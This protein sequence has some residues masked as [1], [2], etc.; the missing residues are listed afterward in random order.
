VG[1]K[2]V[3]ITELVPRIDDKLAAVWEDLAHFCHQCNVAT[4]TTQK[5]SRRTYDDILVS[6]HY[7]LYNI[8]QGTNLLSRALH[9]GVFVLASLLYFAWQYT[10]EG[11]NALAEPLCEILHEMAI[12][13]DGC[14]D[15]VALWLV[16]V[17]KSLVTEDLAQNLHNS[18]LQDR[19][20]SLGL[21]SWE[22]AET[23]LRS[24]IWVDSLHGPRGKMAFNLALKGA[25]ENDSKP[26]IPERSG[27]I[28]PSA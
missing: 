12:D 18:F 25:E 10:P 23:I 21:R 6:V 4:R 13:A 5:F 11:Q 15:P 24:L 22:D 26:R 19:I 17:W 16:M 7:R 28:I 2:A 8:T 20:A 3:N 9:T 1:G 27:V 14:P